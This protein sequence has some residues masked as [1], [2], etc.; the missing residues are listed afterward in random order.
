MCVVIKIWKHG[1]MTFRNRGGKI[2]GNHANGSG[3]GPR[4]NGANSY[5]E[6]WKWN[7]SVGKIQVTEWSSSPLFFPCSSLSSCL[8]RTYTLSLDREALAG[9][10]SVQCY[11]SG[12]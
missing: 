11:A 1:K 6:R 3:C 7:F 10:K 12:A 5:F 9:P 4:I 8:L 2:A